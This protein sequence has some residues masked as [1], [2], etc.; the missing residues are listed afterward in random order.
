MAK[1][2]SF[3]DLDVWQRA[4]QLA[5]AVYRM[6]GSYPDSE[7]FGLVAQMRRAVVSIAANIVEGFKRQGKADKLH[8]YNIAESSLEE[9]KYFFILSQDLGYLPSADALLSEADTIS[10]MLYRLC[11]S[12]RTSAAKQ[13]T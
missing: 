13:Q 5:L 4:H 2:E 9:L 11:E 6:T 10:K 3:R 7:K 8:F 1:L 12:I